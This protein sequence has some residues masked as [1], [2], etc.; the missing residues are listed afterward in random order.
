MG[1]LAGGMGV[2]MM[3]GAAECK[4]AGSADARSRHVYESDGRAKTNIKMTTRVMIRSSPPWLMP[5]RGT[6]GA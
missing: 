1:G 3:D 6:T 2:R 4:A 5:R